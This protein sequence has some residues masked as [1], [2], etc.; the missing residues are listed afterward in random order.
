M[1]G[2][3]LLKASVCERNDLGVFSEEGVND[4]FTLS[5]LVFLVVSGFFIFFLGLARVGFALGLL[6]DLQLSRLLNALLT[7]SRFL[8]LV[9]LSLQDLLCRWRNRSR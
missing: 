2:P 7:T 9:N 4:V 6:L 8:R 1:V 5:C 3:P